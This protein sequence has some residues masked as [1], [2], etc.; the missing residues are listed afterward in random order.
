MRSALGTSNEKFI[1]NYVVNLSDQSSAEIVKYVYNN[2]N[3]SVE[4]FL[5]IRINE[6]RAKSPTLKTWIWFIAQGYLHIVII[7]FP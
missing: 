7:N 2:K 3:T 6:Y 4:C 5:W 1:T